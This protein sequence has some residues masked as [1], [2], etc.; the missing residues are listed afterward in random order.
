MIPERIVLREHEILDSQVQGA[1][2]ASR[3]E[4]PIVVLV[5]V[6]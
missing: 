5:D 3:L 6:S 2:E 1:R 4:V